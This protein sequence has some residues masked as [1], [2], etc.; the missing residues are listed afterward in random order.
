VLP[1]GTAALSAQALSELANAGS[2]KLEPRLDP[3]A[4]RRG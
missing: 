2:R 1:T 4:V 3:E